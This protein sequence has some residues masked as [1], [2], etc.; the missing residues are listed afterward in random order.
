M[1]ID[2]LPM[3]GPHEGR[4]LEFLLCGEKPIAFFMKGFLMSFC[5]ILN[6]AF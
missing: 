4:E 2:S 1:A 6:Q 5:L 3:L